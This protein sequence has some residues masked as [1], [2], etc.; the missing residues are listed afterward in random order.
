MYTCFIFYCMS[1]SSVNFQLTATKVG[2]EFNS[3]KF[4]QIGWTWQ[5]TFHWQLKEQKPFQQ[6]DRFQAWN[7]S[8]QFSIFV[9]LIL[10]WKNWMI[11]HANYC[12]LLSPLIQMNFEKKKTLVISIS[13]C[14]F[15]IPYDRLF[16]ILFL[17]LSLAS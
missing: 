7:V 13:L 2:A 5:G 1:R 8:Q 11:I 17:S 15:I 4:W 3:I 6:I 9:W 16:R 14:I 10:P 12:V